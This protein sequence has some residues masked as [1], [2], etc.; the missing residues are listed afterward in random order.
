MDGAEGI[1]QWSELFPA[2][3]SA[4]A[5]QNLV[6]FRQAGSSIIIYQ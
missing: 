4:R 5:H 2:S 1:T 3:N 6:A